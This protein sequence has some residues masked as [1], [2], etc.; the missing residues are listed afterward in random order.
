MIRRTIWGCVARDSG[1]AQT[2]K[3]LRTRKDSKYRAP[4]EVTVPAAPPAEERRCSPCFT[5]R[6]QPAYSSE[7]GLFSAEDVCSRTTTPCSSEPRSCVLSNACSATCRRGSAAVFSI[8]G[9]SRSAGHAWDACSLFPRVFPLVAFHAAKIP[10]PCCGLT[11]SSKPHWQAA[12]H[13]LVAPRGSARRRR[14]KPAPR[15]RA[16]LAQGKQPGVVGR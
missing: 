8:T 14:P 12:A 3:L 16:L 7:R 2:V 11:T 10:F 1:A 5:W 6:W 13:S 9:P 15:L 4:R